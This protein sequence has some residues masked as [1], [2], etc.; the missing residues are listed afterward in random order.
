MQPA[1]VAGR[2]SQAPL[3]DE[4]GDAPDAL[5]LRGRG[6]TAPP[7]ALPAI[8][9]LR[10]VRVSNNPIA[11]RQA[12]FIGLT[13]VN[14]QCPRGPAIDGRPFCADHGRATPEGNAP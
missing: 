4:A 1:A 13:P 12:W 7:D 9:A 14:V 5:A 6:L 11:P 10:V 3:A 2:C 8:P